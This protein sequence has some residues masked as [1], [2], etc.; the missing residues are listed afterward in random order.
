[1]RISNLKGYLSGEC[2]AVVNNR[3]AIV[4]VPAVQLDAPTALQE[5]LSK[6]DVHK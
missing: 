3:H 2:V 5:H 4:S 6:R 1:M